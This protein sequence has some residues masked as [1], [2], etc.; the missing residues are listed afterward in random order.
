M[1][2]FFL[3]LMCKSWK[4]GGGVGVGV[5]LCPSDVKRSK[6]FCVCE[7]EALCERNL[8]FEGLLIFVLCLSFLC[9]CHR[10]KMFLIS[11]IFSLVLVWSVCFVED[12]CFVQF[13]IRL[14]S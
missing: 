10:R 12:L 7:N 5:I 13:Q 9:W 11:L 4:I 2:C 8:K 14:L 1:S 6:N 3:F